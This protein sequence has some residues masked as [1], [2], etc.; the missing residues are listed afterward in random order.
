MMKVSCERFSYN[1]LQKFK[2]MK[3]VAKIAMGV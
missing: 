1:L 3:S 2:F